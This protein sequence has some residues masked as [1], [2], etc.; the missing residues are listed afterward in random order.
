MPGVPVHMPL[1]CESFGL[2]LVLH[3]RRG[4]HGHVLPHVPPPLHIP[5]TL[6]VV[7]CILWEAA[8]FGGVVRSARTNYSGTLV[9]RIAR[10]GLGKVGPRIGV[11]ARTLGAAWP[12]PRTE[13]A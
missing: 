10:V 3:F 2:G 13:R 8:V 12:W 1:R 4:H 5:R 11:G 9:P 6:Q 7:E